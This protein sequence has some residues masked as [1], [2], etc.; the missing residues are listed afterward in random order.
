MFPLSELGKTDLK[1]AGLK[2]PLEKLFN[3]N[4]P[5]LTD[6][7]VRVGG[8]T[9]S[10]ISPDGLIITNHHC[11]FG[12]V[13]G[14]SDSA[15]DY[16]RAGF[17][18]ADREKEV[19]ANGLVCK[20]TVS[21]EDVSAKVL[22][23]AASISDPI[24]RNKAVKDKMQILL[25]EERKKFPD[26]Q[27]EISEMFIGRTYVLFRYKLLNDVRLVYVP[28]RSIGE[29]GGENDNWV[30]PRHSGDFAILR[31]YVN[32]DGKAAAY[33]KENVPYKPVTHLK[34]N[35]QGVN[36]NDFIFILGY[37]GRTFRH[38]PA[39]FFEYHQRFMLPYISSLYDFHIRTLEQVSKGNKNKEIAFSGKIKSLANT[40]KNYKGKMQGFKRADLL[41]KKQ[42]EEKE[43]QDFIDHSTERQSRYGDVLPRINKIYK[44]IFKDAELNLWVDNVYGASG[45][46]NAAGFVA[47]HRKNLMVMNKEEKKYYLKSQGESLK[48]NFSRSYNFFDLEV[49]RIMLKKMLCD[50]YRINDLGKLAD[51]KKI[52]KIK[53]DNIE[54]SVSDWVDMALEKSKLKDPVWAN[55]LMKEKPEELLM[56]KDPLVDLV[57][58][59]N[60]VLL[61]QDET[62]SKRDAELKILMSRLVDIKQEWK[63]SSF[64]PD[65]NA[66]LRFTYGYIKGYSPANGEYHKPF[67]T[68]KGV[69]EKE[70]NEVYELLQ[71]IKDLYAARDFGS[72]LHPA[73]SD[74]PV[75]FLY[76]LD[77]TGG[78]SGSPVMDAE[79]R[80]IGVNFDRAFTA[81][82]NDYAWNEQYSRSV[83]V[84]IRYILWVL[85]KVA[86]ADHVLREMGV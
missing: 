76:N 30:W 27:S 46:L 62:D 19:P 44:D 32:K 77:T 80:L 22:E 49:D 8:C 81:T 42:A 50:A 82:I 4:A 10:F 70:D 14:I 72:Y 65:A 86:K 25:D 66:T 40:A 15:H 59:I 35:P 55:N 41:E 28:P 73:L 78:N 18:A 26:L 52:I 68:L 31:A 11:A 57:L 47:T 20:I 17:L 83:G 3:P 39:G 53:K 12:Y 38:Y 48:N 45:M 6:A 54:Q 9:G 24:A 13:V 37:P 16:T 64:I 67:T 51:M 71:S 74:I 2:L 79:G 7:I 60:K 33:S 21:Y 75:D 34:V 63:K 29:Y 36:E 84:D 61:E 23:Q 1:K 85:Q 43:L 56:I 5:S 69:I 58:E